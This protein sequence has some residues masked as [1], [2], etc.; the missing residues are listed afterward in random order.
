MKPECIKWVWNILHLLAQ[1]GFTENLCAS[2]IGIAI[3]ELLYFLLRM[4]H[5]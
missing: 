2:R 5:G 1:L 3:Y 4:E